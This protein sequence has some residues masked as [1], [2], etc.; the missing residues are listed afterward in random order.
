[1][2]WIGAESN[3]AGI[4]KEGLATSMGKAEQKETKRR[5]FEQADEQPGAKELRYRDS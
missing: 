5:A 3:R 1:M 2:A 4:T